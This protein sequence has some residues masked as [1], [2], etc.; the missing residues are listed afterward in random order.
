MTYVE[1]IV[2]LSIFS[3]LASVAMYNY[4]GFEDK[5]DIK[6]LSSDIALQLVEAQKASLSGLLPPA[7]F[8]PASTWKPSYGVYFN[9]SA[10]PDTDSIAFNKKFI[11]FTDIDQGGDYDGLTSC[12]SECLTK[13]SIT[14][15]NYISSI[16]VFYASAPSTAVPVPNLTVVFSRPDSGAILSST[17]ALN[18]GVNYAQITIR[19]PKGG[20]ALIKVYS[21]GRIQVN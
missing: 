1:L 16:D 2:V 21:S 10:L 9:S 20:T 3:V 19:S 12:T 8:V 13:T 11:Y 15:N 17:P 5:V 14:K 4:G 6:N 7:I 18:A